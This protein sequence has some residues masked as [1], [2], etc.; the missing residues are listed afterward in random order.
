MIGALAARAKGEGGN[1]IR[2][3]A[4]F[5]WRS[6]RANQESRFCLQCWRVF[7]LQFRGRRAEHR[8]QQRR[9]RRDDRD[10]LSDLVIQA[11]PTC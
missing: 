9:H 2:N 5:V 11:A 7:S 8:K 4:A 1:E 6:A 10:G 3:H